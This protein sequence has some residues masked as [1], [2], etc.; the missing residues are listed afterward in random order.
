MRYLY[1]VILLALFA[2]SPLQLQGQQQAEIDSSFEAKMDRA[3]AEIRK[4]NSDSLQKAVAAEFF[5]YS[6]D[7]PNTKTASNALKSAFVMWGNTG[8]AAEAEQAM[9]YLD[10]D[11]KIWGSALNSISNA[12]ARSENKSWDEDYIPLVKKLSSRLTHPVAKSQALM[13]L[14]DYHLRNQQEKKAKTYY[15]KIVSL[16]AK[17]FFV[18]KAKGNLKEI[19]SLRVGLQA[20]DFTAQ[21]LAG[22][23]FRLSNSE[24]KVVLLEFWATW[25]GPC[26]PQIPH[27]KKLHQQ[28]SDKQLRIIGISLDRETQSLKEFIAEENI[29]WPQ[30]QQQKAWKG[31]IAKQ[32]NA[33]HIPRTYI[34]TGSGEIAAKDLQG[35]ELEEKVSEVIGRN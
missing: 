15:R 3:W 24:A 30:I 22:N 10:D 11:S 19:N 5:Q 35:E 27:L 23:T 29:S 8:S 7:H 2:L 21:T 12:Y 13:K 26:K 4:N 1:T 28:Y 9:K 31:K 25:C 18:Q 34:I 33:N 14:G 16:N 6:R 32:Y 20:P 17:D